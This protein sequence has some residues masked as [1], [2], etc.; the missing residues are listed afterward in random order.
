MVFR[1]RPQRPAPLRCLHIAPLALFILHTKHRS[2]IYACATLTHI[3]T[4]TA[5]TL[6]TH[7]LHTHT[8]TSAAVPAA[9]HIGFATGSPPSVAQAS[10]A[11]DAHIC[12]HTH[13]THIVLPTHIVPEAHTPHPHTLCCRRTLCWRLTHPTHIVCVTP[14]LPTVH[15]PKKTDCP[16]VTCG[17]VLNCVTQLWEKQQP[18]PSRQAAAKQQAGRRQQAGSSRRQVMLALNRN[19]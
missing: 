6:H 15:V 3:H 9:R 19:C 1:E 17:L 13:R 10:A 11:A 18:Y 2:A 5:H 4:Q 7:T 16:I 14:L 8:H 12:R